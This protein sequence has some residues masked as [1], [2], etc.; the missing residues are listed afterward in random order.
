MNDTNIDTHNPIVWTLGNEHQVA[1]HTPYPTLK[2][3]ARNNQNV[4]TQQK[5]KKSTQQ[6]T[7]SN[8][9]IPEREQQTPLK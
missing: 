7:L 6:K 4:Y 5:G 2:T 8:I 1:A 3:I 9:T